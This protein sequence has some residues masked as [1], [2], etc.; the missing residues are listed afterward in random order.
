MKL[1]TIHKARVNH[2]CWV[3]LKLITPGQW[4]SRG[5]WPR[6]RNWGDWHL[7]CG[8]ITVEGFVRYSGKLPGIVRES[9]LSEL[10]QGDD[11]ILQEMRS[12]WSGLVMK[13]DLTDAGE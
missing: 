12:F 4:Y 10:P 2:G 8:M 7:K 6:V 3:C 1:A 5:L 13:G 11:P 9:D